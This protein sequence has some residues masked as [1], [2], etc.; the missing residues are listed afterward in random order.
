MRNQASF[1]RQKSHF[2]ILAEVKLTHWLAITYLD[3]LVC[4]TA[5]ARGPLL[6]IGHQH[7]KSDSSSSINNRN[8]YNRSTSP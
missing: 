7:C 5:L 1:P 6:P 4:Q 2:D 8:Q 3:A